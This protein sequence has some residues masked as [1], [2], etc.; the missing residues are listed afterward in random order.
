[1]E[2][3][4][5]ESNFVRDFPLITA[6]LFVFVKLGM[7][8]IV[9]KYDFVYS[10][11]DIAFS[12]L[13]FD[14]WALTSILMNDQPLESDRPANKAEKSLIVLLP[15][16]HFV[17]YCAFLFPPSSSTAMYNQF[18]DQHLLNMVLSAVATYVVPVLLLH[19]KLRNI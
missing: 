17:T 13:S 8:K 7:F 9:G 1:M 11:S 14:L 18:S 4:Q 5:P 12:G 2:Q 15:F 10:P 6:A 19:R 16:L 3:K